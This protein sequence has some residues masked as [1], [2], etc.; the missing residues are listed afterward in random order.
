MIVVKQVP[1]SG[2]TGMDLV[3]EEIDP[4]ISD[5]EKYFSDPSRAGTPLTYLE[6]DILRSFLWYLLK[7]S[8]E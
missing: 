1:V 8:K 4:V 5:F 2:K 3:R 7:E 6:R